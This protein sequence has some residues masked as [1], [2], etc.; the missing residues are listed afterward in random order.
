MKRIKRIFFLLA[1]LALFVGV[2]FFVSYRAENSLGKATESRQ[3]V[4]EKGDN[5]TVIA[6]K[7][8]ENELIS[9]E[10]YFIYYVWTRE[11]SGKLLA[12]EYEIEPKLKI[13]EIT[14]LL[15]KGETKPSYAKV[16]F[17]EGWTAEDMAKRL[18]E[19]KLPGDEFLEIVIN[20]PTE[21]VAQF[22]FFE[23][24]PAKAS[25]EGYLFPDTYFISFEESAENIVLR[26][27][28]NFDGKFSQEMKK[29]I[30]NQ[31][32][33]IFE[34]VTM[35][36][37]IES[38]VRTGNDRKIVSGIFWNRLGIGMALQ[39]DA[40]V[41]YVLGGEKKIQ[42]NAED[43]NINSPYNTYKFKGL[44]PGP[45]SNPGISSIEAAI[46]PTETDYMYFLNNPKTGET[47]FSVT[48]QEHIRNKT[49]NG[50]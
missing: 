29:E 9:R 35:A 43:I 14:R 15:V 46:N 24:K 38:E 7:L 6:K 22:S 4:I 5:V 11:L 30:K 3:V 28:K 10:A 23:D 50:L 1:L 12:G 20:P 21:I 19:K 33:G 2:F 41:A 40:T 16:T 27:L 45:V 26:M 34:I 32:K 48:F 36:S 18:N 42:H 47:F 37:I 44:P 49:A 17:P 39:S 8:K 13:P 31:K 25:L